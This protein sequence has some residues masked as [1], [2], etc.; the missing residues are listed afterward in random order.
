MRFGTEPNEFKFLI[1]IGSMKWR[2]LSWCKQYQGFDCS[3]VKCDVAS[4]SDL[5]CWIMKLKSIEIIFLSG[6]ICVLKNS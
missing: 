5:Q 1:S 3:D 4:D 6:L 2:D